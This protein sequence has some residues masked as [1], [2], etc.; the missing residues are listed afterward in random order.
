MLAAGVL[1]A[2]SA[3]SDIPCS[4]NYLETDV[5]IIK[6]SDETVRDEM[7]CK[8]IH[9]IDMPQEA[10]NILAYVSYQSMIPYAWG[11]KP[12]TPSDCDVKN[13]L[14][15]KDLSKTDEQV[16]G[17]HWKDLYDLFTSRAANVPSQVQ[18]L[19]ASISNDKLTEAIET[20]Y[21]DV[22]NSVRTYQ[23]RGADAHETP[24]LRSTAPVL[25]TTTN[26]ICRGLQAQI[27]S[28]I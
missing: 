16:N 3:A 28:K 21:R 27:C 13:L 11:G 5:N 25:T 1:L 6:Q 17:V 4:D 8:T 22:V 23:V 12:M 24:Y 19:V 2:V 15:V 14:F 10:D 9:E 20:I 7:E 18:T 26:L